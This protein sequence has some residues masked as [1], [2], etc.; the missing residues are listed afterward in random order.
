MARVNKYKS[1]KDVVLAL[2]LGETTIAKLQ[3]IK[4]QAKNKGDTTY[5]NLIE[6]GIDSYNRL[7]RIKEVAQ[8]GL[9]PEDILQ[10]WEI[11][12]EVGWRGIDEK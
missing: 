5:T 3:K 7:T 4:W 10:K 11:E 2:S 12:E 6:E 1:T 8:L 9:L